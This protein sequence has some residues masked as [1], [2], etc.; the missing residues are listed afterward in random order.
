[1]KN[2][3]DLNQAE[4]L[5]ELNRAWLIAAKLLRDEGRTALAVDCE[6]LQRSIEYIEHHLD[7]GEH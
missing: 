4:M 3:E 7:Y 1:M 6:R 5:T 2:V